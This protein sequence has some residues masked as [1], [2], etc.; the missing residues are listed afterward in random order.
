MK[1]NVKLI[2]LLFQ[3]HIMLEVFDRNF[4]FSSVLV[5]ES[6]I[7][8]FLLTSLNFGRALKQVALQFLKVLKGVCRHQHFAM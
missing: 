2:H 1:I 7:F 8:L 4:C 5:T 3:G 6:N